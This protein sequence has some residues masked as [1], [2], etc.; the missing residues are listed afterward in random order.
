LHVTFGF[1]AVKLAH[2]RA[3]Q[4]KWSASPRAQ[5]R[6]LIKI[7]QELIHDLAQHAEADKTPAPVTTPK[8]HRKSAKPKELAA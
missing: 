6:R 1:V 2:K 4:E 5:R 7:L 8:P 3:D